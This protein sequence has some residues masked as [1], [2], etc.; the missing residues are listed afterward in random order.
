MQQL[1]MPDQQKHDSKCIIVQFS[2][3]SIGSVDVKMFAY[4]LC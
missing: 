3:F 2:W 1:Y 4:N